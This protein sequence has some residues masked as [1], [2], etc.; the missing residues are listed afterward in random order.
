[1]NRMQL[2]TLVALIVLAGWTLGRAQA[3]I[4]NFEV[5]VEA[6]RGPIQVICDRGCD[7]GANE[8]ALVCESERCRWSFT[9]HG[10]VIVG[11]PR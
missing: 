7:W 8:G 6:G 9:G 10:R 11:Q 5:T 2:G 3:P 1:M 4:A